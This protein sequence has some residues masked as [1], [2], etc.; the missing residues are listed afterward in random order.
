MSKSSLEFQLIAEEPFVKAPLEQVKKSIR[1]SQKLLE[2]GTSHIVHGLEGLVDR[3]ER[4]VFEIDRLL[5]D[6]HE[7]KQ[8]VRE[9]KRSE[10]QLLEKSKARIK[11]LARLSDLHLTDDVG[12][13][14]WSR[15]RLDRMLIDYMLR[16]GYHTTAQH[17]ID[18]KGLEAFADSEL[19]S[20]CARIESALI[21]SHSCAEALQWCV[22]N[23]T[24]L[25]KLD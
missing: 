11:H 14:E 21:D 8:N 23:R 7:L 24:V 10:A 17:L 12:Y 13:R 1:H 25:R 19:F 20:A 2:N 18:S 6:L 15:V 4:S 9:C 5:N 16:A 22:E 3:P